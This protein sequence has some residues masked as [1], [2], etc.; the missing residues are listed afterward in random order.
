MQGEL[1]SATPRAITTL[2]FASYSCYL[3]R[4]ALAAIRTK[5]LVSEYSKNFR[6]NLVIITTLIKLTRQCL[7]RH[8]PSSETIL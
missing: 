7:L 3:S 5:K 8:W 1:H 4:I 2:A 6:K